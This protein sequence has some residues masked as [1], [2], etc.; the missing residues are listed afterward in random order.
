MYYSLPTDL[1]LIPIHRISPSTFCA[2]KK[3]TLHG[4]LAMS[5]IPKMLPSSPNAYIGSIIHETIKMAK[6]GKISE[7][8]DFE[9][10][11][12]ELVD[13]KEKAMAKSWIEKHL[14]PIKKYSTDYEVKKLLCKKFINNLS[15][16]K[17]KLRQYSSISEKF[18]LQRRNEIWLQS[19]DGKVGG[20]VDTII[21]TENGDIIIDY[22]TGKYIEEPSGKNDP[23]V[24]EE[25]EIQLK[26][27]SSLYNLEYGKWPVSLKIA[28]IDGTSAEVN[29]TITECEVMLREAIKILNYA[30]NIITKRDLTKSEKLKELSSPKPENCKFCQY[31]PGCKSYLEIMPQNIISEKK[32]PIDVSGTI[33]DRKILGNGNLFIKLSLDA[34]PSKIISIRNLSIERHPALNNIGNKVVMFSLL[35][36]Y[37]EK[38]YQE[39]LLTTSYQSS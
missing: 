5:K 17:Q 4:T 38:K 19:T 20:Y 18:I 26:L 30:N 6:E 15:L 39:G 36:D 31:R 8:N 21:P 2:F 27:Y 32:W 3:C 14:V 16:E 7:K 25:Y 24:K 12:S 1:Q 35:A 33:M 10:I 23:T 13:K 9:S 22:K 37:G 11:W 28:G 34:E 29:F